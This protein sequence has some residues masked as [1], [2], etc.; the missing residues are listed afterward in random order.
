MNYW[1]DYFPQWKGKY[2]RSAQCCEVYI[3]VYTDG[4][5][6]IVEAN[7]VRGDSKPFM[8][9]FKEFKAMLTT[10]AAPVK[11]TGSMFLSPL[12]SQIV[13][14]EQFLSGIKPIFTMSTEPFMEARLEGVKMLCELSSHETA[15]LG[16]EECRTQIV[17]AL[18]RL[19]SDEMDDVKQHGIMAVS[20]FINLVDIPDYKTGIIASSSLLGQLLEFAEDASY[21][22]YDSIHARRECAYILHKL[23]E[24]NAV[25]TTRSLEQSVGP[26]RLAQWLN[27]H[28]IVS[29]TR[30]KNYIASAR[31]SFS[32]IKQ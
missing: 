13:T 28:A 9:F 3:T 26:Q 2:I 14:D 22:V 32:K 30:L 17:C 31:D 6:F 23:F 16:L 1:F 19:A 4:A 11:K 18:E 27:S 8:K 24:F 20:N 29:D 7:R 25:A 15:L 12:P 21:P 5:A 10:I